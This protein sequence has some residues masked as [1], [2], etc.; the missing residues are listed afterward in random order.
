[1]IMESLSMGSSKRVTLRIP[2]NIL[3]ILK[4][5]SDKRV[6]PLNALIGRIL[7]NYVN[8]DMNKNILATIT[9]SQL[10]FSRI[11]NRL[12][13]SEKNELALQ[14]PKTVKQLFALLN[15]EYNLPN[16]IENYFAVVGKYCGWYSFD[17]YSD[18]NQYRLVFKSEFDEEWI[19]FLT[20]Y[21]RVILQSLNVKIKN[22]KIHDCVI[23]FEIFLWHRSM[24]D[25]IRCYSTL[26][27]NSVKH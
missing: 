3:K 5:E 26:I 19:K 16:V 9:M 25:D 17:H 15:L 2:E 4:K 27:I 6:L 24:T 21:I 20:L 11:V 7:A 8:F 1:M 12:N 13:E 14:G 22:E 23:L 10:L 18:K